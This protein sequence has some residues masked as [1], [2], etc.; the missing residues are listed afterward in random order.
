MNTII[1]CRKFRISIIS[2]VIF[3]LINHLYLFT[4]LLLNNDTVNVGISGDS[5]EHCISFG[6]WFQWVMNAF[7][8]RGVPPIVNGF[9]SLIYIAVSIFLLIEIFQ[10]EEPAAIICLSAA[11]SSFPVLAC[12]FLYWYNADTTWLAL[13]LSVLS[14]YLIR[15]DFKRNFVPAVILLTLSCGIYQVFWCFAIGLLFVSLLWDFLLSCDI[16]KYFKQG[17]IYLL[18][19]IC[20]IILYAII[21]KLLQNI[22]NIA[23]SSYKGLDQ[24]GKFNSIR[25][26]YWAVKG[27]YTSFFSFYFTERTFTISKWIIIA[28][29][30]CFLFIIAGISYLIFSRK[31]SVTYKLAVAA[32][33]IASPLAINTLS[34]I[35]KNQM[36]EVN[37]IAYI[38]P[39]C[40]LISLLNYFGY[41]I[42]D[43]DSKYQLIKPYILK[44]CVTASLIC[45]LFLTYSNYLITNKLYMR[46]Q[47]NYEATFAYLNRLVFRIEETSGYTPATPVYILN[48]NYYNGNHIEIFKNKDFLPSERMDPVFS[49]LDENVSVLNKYTFISNTQDIK[50]FISFYFGMNINIIEDGELMDTVWSLPEVQEMG[51]YPDKSGVLMMDDFLV[52]K[53]PD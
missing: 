4:N 43:I 32:L 17:C 41:T 33:L 44:S 7:S 14:V 24:A 49:T 38:I 27:A 1:H 52:I 50:D 29:T 51:V 36:H 42:K 31:T 25:E 30:L 26:L 23:A 39:Y 28:N 9:L 11:F 19:L 46:T 6:R 37:M 10:I 35:S 3:M 12:D 47:L 48:E 8:S 2:T 53:L 16:Q 20:S 13:L 15:K 45:M 5:F 34:V 22:T 40:F 18:S 21:T